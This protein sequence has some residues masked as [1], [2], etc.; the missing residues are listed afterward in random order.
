M[1]NKILGKISEVYFG[2]RDG[3]LGLW[4][5]L[6]GSWG[7]M[8]DYSCWNPQYI[9][10]TEHTKWTED[11]RKMEMAKIMNK[12]AELLKKAKVSNINDLL[13]IP[14]E[15]TSKGNTLSSWRILEEVL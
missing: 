13:N 8:T 2:D 4:L 12:V 15:M 1:E 3:R 6:S 10:V 9:K 5:T 7:V 11:D 14:I